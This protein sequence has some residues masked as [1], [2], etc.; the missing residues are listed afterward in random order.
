MNWSHG[1]YLCRST[2][3]CF[4][5]Q[6]CWALCLNKYVCVFGTACTVQ[7]SL[8]DSLVRHQQEVN[9]SWRS[10]DRISAIENSSLNKIPNTGL[11]TPDLYPHSDAMVTGDAFFQLNTWT[12]ICLLSR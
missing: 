3:L 2:I 8:K 4:L 10:T 9:L 5:S 6:N 1:E 7:V 12:L 11:C